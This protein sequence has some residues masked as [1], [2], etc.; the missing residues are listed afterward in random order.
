MPSC[1]PYDDVIT[2]FY[3]LPHITLELL[4][5]N[6]L[7]GAMLFLY[8]S[9]A[10][11]P[12]SEVIATGQK[13]GK[14]QVTLVRFHITLTSTV[15]IRSFFLRFYLETTYW[16]NK[17]FFAVTCEDLGPGYAIH[18]CNHR[19]ERIRQRDRIPLL[20]RQCLYYFPFYFNLVDDP[21][22][23]NRFKMCRLMAGFWPWWIPAR[24]TCCP[25]GTGG[26]KLSKER[27]P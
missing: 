8:F 13:S 12:F 22:F 11:H 21:R 23:Q 18:S 19:T 10:L 24:T 17:M 26:T 6:D 2:Q 27:H 7:W 25:S 20:W 1:Q 9:M 3:F 5:H 14:T 4:V 15:I 16:W